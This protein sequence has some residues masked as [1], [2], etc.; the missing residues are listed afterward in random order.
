MKQ[1]PGYFDGIEPDLI[2]VA[3]RL[4]EALALESLL[5]DSGIDYGVEA[6][7]YTGGV[8]FKTTRVGAF[9]YVRPEFREA[10]VNVLLANGY[11]PVKGVEGP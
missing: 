5:N 8:V 10:A 1:V 3:K 2:F 6:D 11:V 4:R 7:E 9:F